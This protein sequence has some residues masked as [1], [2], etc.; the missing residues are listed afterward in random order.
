MN[1]SLFKQTN[2]SYIELYRNDF[3]C[4][5]FQFSVFLLL[6]IQGNMMVFHGHMKHGFKL[7]AGLI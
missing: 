1:Y 4:E 2:P 5:R 6:V 3:D 7:I